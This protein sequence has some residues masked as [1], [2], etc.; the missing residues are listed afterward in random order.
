MLALIKMVSITLSGCVIIRN[1]KI[2]LLFRKKHSH[3]E[4][5]GGKQKKGETLEQ[6]AMREV[7]EEI[8]CGV[9]I[10]KYLG[11]KDFSLNKKTFRNHRFLAE[12]NQSEVP[13]LMEPEIF[14][15]ISWIP[16]RDYKKYLVAYNVKLFCEQYIN[17]EIEL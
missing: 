5:P 1:E 12:L 11:Y 13:K 3:Y 16:I 9:K 10:I 8:G 6:T 15:D 7:K 4:F 14:R 2:L 17:G